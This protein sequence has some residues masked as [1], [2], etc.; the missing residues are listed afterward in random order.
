[1]ILKEWTHA[2][3]QLTCLKCGQIVKLEASGYSWA[4]EWCHDEWE[5]AE[6]LAGWVKAKGIHT[7]SVSLE[8]AREAMKR[9]R[10]THPPMTFEEEVKLYQSLIHPT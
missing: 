7:C 4:R 9:Y 10:A 6:E 2:S 5:K 1:M 3:A 8:M